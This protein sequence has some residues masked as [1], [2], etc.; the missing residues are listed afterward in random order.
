MWELTKSIFTFVR[1]RDSES[2][3][4]LLIVLAEWLSEGHLEEMAQYLS[5]LKKFREARKGGA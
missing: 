2:A 3:A 1:K 4:A 5:S